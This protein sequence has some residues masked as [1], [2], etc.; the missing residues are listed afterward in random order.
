M[1][2]LAKY[3]QSFKQ[4]V[5]TSVN[6]GVME[7]QISFFSWRDAADRRLIADHHFE[8]HWNSMIALLKCDLNTRHKIIHTSLINK[9]C[10]H[11]H[12]MSLAIVINKIQLNERKSVKQHYIKHV[13]ACLHFLETSTEAQ[14]RKS[15]TSNSITESKPSLSPT[16]H[17]V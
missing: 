6:Y 14:R 3:C 8:K 16:S 17:R 9:I 5:L 1:E 13:F 4:F 11:N 10:K 2:P 7:Y 15:Q 12:A